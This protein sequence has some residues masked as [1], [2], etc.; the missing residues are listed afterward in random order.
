MIAIGPVPRVTAAFCA[1][2][3][4]LRI[5]V[6]RSVSYAWV[7]TPDAAA[8]AVPTWRLQ[9]GPDAV[10]E[11]GVDPARRVGSCASAWL[12]TGTQWAMVLRVR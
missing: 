3:S 1:L 6:R 8:S 12:V 7:W 9:L 5:V 2:V 11:V 4:A 10:D